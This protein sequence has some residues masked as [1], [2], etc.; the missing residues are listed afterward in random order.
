MSFLEALSPLRRHKWML[1]T[2]WILSTV[3]LYL[4]IQLIPQITKSTVYFSVKPAVAIEKE[5][6]SDGVEASEKLAEAIAGWAKDPNFRVAVQKNA[7]TNIP[8]FK[9]KLSARKQN[10]VNVFWTVTLTSEEG[11][12]AEKINN[13]LIQTINKNLEEYNEGNLVPLLITPPRSYSEIQ[14]LPI[15]WIITGVIIIGLLLSFV[16]TYLIESLQN[17]VSYHHQIS[18]IFGDA[19]T[20]IIPTKIGSHDAKL[21]EQFIL[22]FN[23]PRLLST[24][25]SAEN[26]F[27]LAPRDTI[28]ENDTVVLLVKLGSTTLTELKNMKA[29]FGEAVGVIVFEK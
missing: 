22:T 20:L 27:S 18:D 11:Q 9:R 24:F 15:S 16:I 14:S 3:G 29:I 7:G 23:S 10:R 8:H 6:V 13:A 5:M 21:L 12:L 26:F 17:K 19:P 25:S 28:G 4:L 2:I 1:L